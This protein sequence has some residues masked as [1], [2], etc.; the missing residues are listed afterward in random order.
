[1]FLQLPRGY[2]PGV[3]SC[4]AD[5]AACAGQRKSRGGVWTGSSSR[6]APASSARTSRTRCSSAATG[7]ASSTRSPTRCTAAKRPAY[8]DD[9]VELIIGDVRDREAVRRALDGVDAVVH[10]AARV[11]VGQSMYEIAE[12]VAANSHGTA[13]LLEALLDHPVRK[14]LVASSMSIYGEGAYEP[15]PAVERTK[16]D[17]EARRWEP[18]GAERRGR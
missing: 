8:L 13:V 12:Y 6:V 5:A 9:D 18:R 2:C 15:V 11:G 7:F 16:A 1:M 4:D 10:F 17:L 14:L 3:R